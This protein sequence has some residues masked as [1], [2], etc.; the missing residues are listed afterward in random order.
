VEVN[1]STVDGKLKSVPKVSFFLYL[2]FLGK[3]RS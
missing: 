2:F 3:D 1:V